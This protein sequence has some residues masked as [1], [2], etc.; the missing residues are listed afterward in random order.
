MTYINPNWKSRQTAIETKFLFPT[1]HRSERM[2]ATAM[3]GFHNEKKLSVTIPYQHELGFEG[4]SRKAAEQ[5]L[6][7]MVEYPDDVNDYSMVAG[8]TDYGL[9]FVI[10]EKGDD[11]WADEL[12]PIAG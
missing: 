1:K 4:T 2:K 3:V 8:D 9:V 11:P 7:K 10:V 5:L 12:P 6:L